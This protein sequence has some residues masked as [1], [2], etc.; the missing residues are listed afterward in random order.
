VGVKAAIGCANGSDAL[1]LSL[2]ALEIG[3]GDEVITTPFTFFATA[4]AIARAG[5]T[6]VFVDIDPETFNIDPHRI[7]ARITAKTKAVMAVH[8]FG[9]MADCDELLRVSK[10]HKLALIEDGAQA[11]GS[12][13]KGASAGTLGAMGTFSFFP[14]KNLGGSGD[15]GM[16][17][18]NDGALPDRLRM[19]RVHGSR[20]KYHHELLGINSRLDSLQ[21]AILEVK[22]KYL[23]GWTAARR[24]K[25]AFYG[26]LFTRYEIA[27]QHVSLPAIDSNYRHVFNQY[28]IR[29]GRRDELK[30]HLASAGITTEIYYPLPLHL[31]PAFAYL[32]YEKGD[33]P[34]SESAC[35]TV[36]ALP[37]YPELGERQQEV[38]VRAIGDFYSQRKT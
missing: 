33:L 3:P 19:L 20:K 28:V 17:V 31:Q 32:G 16:I 26:D 36:L 27:P 5:A 35:E 11:I 2:L 23:D 14:S 13:Y 12:A 29:C 24:S 9:R 6:P 1:F 30:Q 25:A 38:I 21:A 10:E 7:E 4:G 37:I 18:T 8:L 15:G 34:E 22:L